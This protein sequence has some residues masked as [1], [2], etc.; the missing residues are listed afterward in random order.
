M[1]RRSLYNTTGNN[2]IALGANAGI[3]LTTGSNNIDIGNA[4]G[5]A[6]ESNKIRIGTVGTQ[7]ATFIAGIS[8]ATVPEGVGVIVGNNGKLGTI[9]SSQRFKDNVQ[10]MDKASEAIL[11]LQ[12]VTFHYKRDLDPEASRSSASWPSRSKK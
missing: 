4:G 5:V 1:I 8:G 2:N 9:V 11:A 10:P 12:P 7:T 3:N 6:G